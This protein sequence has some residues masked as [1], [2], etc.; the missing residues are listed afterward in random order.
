LKGINDYPDP[1]CV[2]FC[3]GEK[4]AATQVISNTLEPEWDQEFEVQLEK[5]QVI[6]FR[7]KDQ[8]ILSRNTEIGKVGVSCP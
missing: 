7:V 2:I 1:Y 3:D 4:L 5:A 8:N 6:E